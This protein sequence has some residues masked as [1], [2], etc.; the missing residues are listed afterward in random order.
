MYVYVHCSTFTYSQL[1]VAAFGHHCNLFPHLV[2]PCTSCSAHCHNFVLC[3]AMINNTFSKLRLGQLNP[4]L[5]LHCHP[6]GK[7][8]SALTLQSITIL[9]IY[10]Y[11]TMGSKGI[12]FKISSMAQ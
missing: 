9:Y 12:Q 10:F 5:K 6:V 3:L 2:S 1:C 7:L 4:N 8:R 11:C